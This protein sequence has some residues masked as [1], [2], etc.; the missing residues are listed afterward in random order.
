MHKIMRMTKN[1]KIEDDVVVYQIR[2]SS[3]DGISTED[4][5]IETSLR[6][7]YDIAADKIRLVDDEYMYG[8]SLPIHPLL[9]MGIGEYKE[10]KYIREQV[11]EALFPYVNGSDGPFYAIT[12]FDPKTGRKVVVETTWGDTVSVA[13]TIDLFVEEVIFYASDNRFNN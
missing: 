11:K 8:S 2:L 10:R 3:Y 9:E 12:E 7:V 5:P 13:T 1:V 4:T 6:L